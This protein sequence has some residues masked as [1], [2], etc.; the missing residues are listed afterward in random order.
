MRAALLAGA[1]MVGVAALAVPTSA[2]H[3]CPGSVV[4]VRGADRP[5]CDVAR[6]QRL[7]VILPRDADGE[8]H[9][10]LVY[11]DRWGGELIWSPRTN[12][13]TCEG[14]DF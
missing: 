3:T 1:A 5:S 7:D 8:L 12:E 9:G 14:V 4:T 11:C 10:A 6:G 2:R 13:A